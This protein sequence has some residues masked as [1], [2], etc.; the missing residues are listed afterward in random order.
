M[1]IAAIEWHEGLELRVAECALVVVVWMLS[2]M[3]V[4]ALR[5]TLVLVL[6]ADED[7]GDA[8]RLSGR[9]VHHLGGIQAGEVRRPGDGEPQREVIRGAHMDARRHAFTRIGTR[10][11][12]AKPIV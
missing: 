5:K 4:S 6:Q 9:T 10:R 11:P 3:H 8:R 12:T 2:H 7:D 1:V